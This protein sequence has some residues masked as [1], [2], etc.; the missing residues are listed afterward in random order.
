MDI[1]IFDNGGRTRDRY[2]LIIDK[3]VVYTMTA[4]SHSL[5]D[6]R[7]LCEMADL[8]REAAGKLTKLEDL[9]K[10]LRKVIEI[11]G[12]KWFENVNRP[13]GQ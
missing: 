4:D 7:Y 13:S 12:S 8:D 6:V 3:S 9:P 11:H 10:G 5:K 1:Q 2:C